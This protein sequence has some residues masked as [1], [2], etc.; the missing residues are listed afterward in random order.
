MITTLPSLQIILTMAADY[1]VLHNQLPSRESWAVKGFYGVTWHSI[2]SALRKK[3][4]EGTRAKSLP[5][6]WVEKF[7]ER[8]INNLPELSV[9]KILHWCDEFFNDIGKFPTKKSLPAKSMGTETFMT[10]DTALRDQRRRLVG[11][12]SLAD[13]LLKHR[14]RRHNFQTPS[15][16]LEIIKE[17]MISWHRLRGE[18]PTSTDGAIPG[19][20]GEKWTNINAV[21]HRGGRR[22]PKGTSLAK[23]KL[24]LAIIVAKS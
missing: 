8:N 14:S 1:K 23:L 16:N 18:W 17:W 4:I 5:D 22:L 2:N 13:L 15:L 24:D 6:L 20:N 3:K 11:Y 10:I 19:T 7:G 12:K 21:L 9:D